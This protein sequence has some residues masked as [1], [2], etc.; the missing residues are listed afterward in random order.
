VARCCRRHAACGDGIWRPRFSSSVRALAGYRL[1][2]RAA[3]PREC[4][5]C[6]QSLRKQPTAS[7]IGFVAESFSPVTRP[8]PLSCRSGWALSNWTKPEGPVRRPRDP[9]ALASGCSRQPTGDDDDAA[10][11][12]IGAIWASAPPTST[13]CAAALARRRC[14]RRAL[15][16]PNDRRRNAVFHR[17][18]CI[19]QI[20]VLAIELVG[21]IAAYNAEPAVIK[22]ADIELLA[23][24]E[25]DHFGR[26][27]D[28]EA[29][30]LFD[31][32]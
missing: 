25:R 3:L 12:S 17:R 20:A 32:R 19:A 10:V 22:A 5:P 27:I 29:K 2:P 7:T 26:L 16:C 28:P 8:G 23:V 15:T 6:R 21:Y 18:T 9:H 4:A 1:V 14:R 30:I 24:C 11:F 31:A 13:S